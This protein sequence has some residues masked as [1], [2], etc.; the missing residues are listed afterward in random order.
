MGKKRHSEN[1]KPRARP[2]FKH[3][4]VD[5]DEVE[6]ENHEEE[7]GATAAG[8]DATHVHDDGQDKKEA[9]A[10]D[11]YDEGCCR[12]CMEDGIKRSCCDTYFCD[13]CYCKSLPL[14]LYH[15]GD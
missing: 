11:G 5:A 14:L 4:I 9:E 8:G 2:K 6:Q 7:G 1:G 13:E 12:L 10:N 15:D 3:K